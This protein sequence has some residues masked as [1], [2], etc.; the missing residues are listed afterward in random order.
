MFLSQVSLSLSLSLLK[1]NIKKNSPLN[2]FSTMA[3]HWV[4]TRGQ[5]CATL[6]IVTTRLSFFKAFN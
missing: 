6:G 3:I 2:C 4:A 5:G 1:L